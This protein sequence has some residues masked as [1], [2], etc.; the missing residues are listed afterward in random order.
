MKGTAPKSVTRVITSAFPTEFEAVVGVCHSDDELVSKGM[1]LLD[2]LQLDALLVTRSEK[3]MTLLRHAHDALH[4]PALTR[5]VFDV[6]G[7][8]D[9]VIAVFTACLARG[10]DPL[11]AAQTAN[12]AAGVVVGK[13]GTATATWDEIES[14]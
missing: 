8:G 5:E 7:A 1:Q 12:L 3:G 14:H 4:F 2:E 13:V 11:K 10:D 9:T 6:T